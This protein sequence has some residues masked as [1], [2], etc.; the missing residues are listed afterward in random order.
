MIWEHSNFFNYWINYLLPMVN[1]K[2]LST[3]FYIGTFVAFLLVRA[4]YTKNKQA[5][6]TPLNQPIGNL[7]NTK[8]H[9]R[10]NGIGGKW[11]NFGSQSVNQF[12]EKISSRLKVLDVNLT[13]NLFISSNSIDSFRSRFILLPKCFAK[14]GRILQFGFSFINNIC[15]NIRNPSETN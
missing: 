6:I 4:K 11:A 12:C 8:K 9:L 13:K 5:Q 3:N 10:K 2:F 7:Q 1:Q 14:F 15:C